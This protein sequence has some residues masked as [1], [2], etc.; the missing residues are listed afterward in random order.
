MVLVK[1]TPLKL[2][3]VEDNISLSKNIAEFMD[4]HNVQ[5]D[6]AY[7]GQMAC[8]LALSE[9]FDC[10]VLDLTMPKMDGL[11]ACKMIREQANR[12][13]PIIM[14]TARDSLDDKLTGFRYGADDYLTKPFALEELLVRIQVIAARVQ[15]QN[16]ARLCHGSGEN[17][18][19]LDISANK[20]FRAKQEI[21]LPPIAFKIFSILM[22]A[23]PRTVS[24]S[25]LLDKIWQGD[26]TDSDALRSHLY[27][28]RKA[29][30]KPFNSEVIK[31]IHGV[32]FG[33]KIN[34][35]S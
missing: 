21:S 18:L 34:G 17:Q 26:N 27:Q 35:E 11:S 14:L 12:H 5:L 9:H 22:H 31:T 29:I 13:I 28:L 33:L 23:H 7:D 4:A 19:V 16:S 24:R 2:L 10:I 1:D 25:E 32:G 8:D 30:D 20:V 15:S 3:V 6:F